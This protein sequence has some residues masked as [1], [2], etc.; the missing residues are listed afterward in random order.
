MRPHSHLAE[1]LPGEYPES[2]NVG[3]S[4]YL[5]LLS[6]VTPQFTEAEWNLLYD[7]CNGWATQL[8]PPETLAQGLTLQV[9]DAT[10]EQGLYQKWNVEPGLIDRLY[11]LTLLE[12]IAVIHKIEQFW[13]RD[14]LNSGDENDQSRNA[15][16]QPKSY[17][18]EQ[19]WRNYLGLDSDYDW[20]DLDLIAKQQIVE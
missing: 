12:A 9:E 1:Q 11:Q 10:R 2:V 18:A 4:R 15:I 17:L 13:N 7:S 8:E 16:H 20:S 6:A 19:L 5:C 14:E 3:L